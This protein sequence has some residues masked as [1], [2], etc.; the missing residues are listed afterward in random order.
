MELSRQEYWSGLPFP[1]QGDLPD[2][3]IEPTF[4]AS[5]ALAGSFF[6]TEPPGKPYLLGKMELIGFATGQARTEEVAQQPQL[7]AWF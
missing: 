1:A 3:G 7:T 2:Q 5:P 6:T 4:R